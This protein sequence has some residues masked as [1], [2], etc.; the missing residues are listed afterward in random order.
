MRFTWD[1]DYAP[2][3]ADRF[4]G[5][6]FTMVITLHWSI[7]TRAPPFIAELVLLEEILHFY[8]PV[9]SAFMHNII[10]DY[11]K[12][13]VLNPFFEA[14]EEAKHKGFYPLDSW[15]DIW[16]KI[17]LTRNTFWQGALPLERL[18]EEADGSYTIIIDDRPQTRGLY[19]WQRVFNKISSSLGKEFR[20]NQSSKKSSHRE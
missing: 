12:K 10:D 17:F 18:K 9:S 11:I 15:W 8:L 14:I 5:D 20:E 7:I 1:T 6:V 2:F 13:E 16:F 4:L 3:S 19:R